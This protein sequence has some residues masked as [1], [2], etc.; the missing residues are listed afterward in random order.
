MD[1]NFER[2]RNKNDRCVKGRRGRFICLHVPTRNILAKIKEKESGKEEA[3]F[4]PFRSI[5]EVGQAK[6]KTSKKENEERYRQRGEEILF[7]TPFISI[8][9]RPRPRFSKTKRREGGFSGSACPSE[10]EREWVI[11]KEVWHYCR[12]EGIL[13]YSGNICGRSLPRSERYRL[14]PGPLYLQRQ[15]Q[16]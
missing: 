9:N 7:I 13:V 11:I 5:R 8:R 1:S 16:T 2:S 6:K 3:S 4:E 12:G 14:P 15:W 10:R